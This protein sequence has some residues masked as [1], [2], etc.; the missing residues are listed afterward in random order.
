MLDKDL[1]QYYE[2][3]ADLF[4]TSGWKQLV[5]LMKTTQEAIES[6]RTVKDLRD[7]DFRQG[8]LAVIDT[9][10]NLPL[11]IE[12]AVNSHQEVVE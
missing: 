1:E 8:Q 12:L 9:I 7:L 4:V 6:V 2:S 10:L 11:S 5:E 3:F